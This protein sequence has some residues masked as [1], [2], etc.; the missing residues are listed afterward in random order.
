MGEVRP[1]EQGDVAPPFH[2]AIDASATLP[3]T[4]REHR[5][6]GA[7]PLLDLASCRRRQDRLRR[8]MADRSLDA[9][10]V[11]APEHVQYLTGHRWDARFSPLAAV[12]ASGDVL[13]VCPDRPVDQAAADERID[14]EQIELLAE[15]AMVAALCFFDPLQVRVEIFLA[16]PRGAVEPL[17]LLTR[18]IAFH[19]DGPAGAF[20]S[21]D[22]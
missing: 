21:S 9:V 15:D 18:G 1:R 20:S 5:M 6:N 13:L 8:H 22:W 12:L 10:V 11:V 4:L 14:A 3:H 16:E 2:E 7:E 17:E 19:A